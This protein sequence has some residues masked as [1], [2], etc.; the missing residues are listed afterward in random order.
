MSAL[1]ALAAERETFLS[2]RRSGIGGTD[3]AAI[4]GVSPWKTPLQVWAEKTGKISEPDLSE[5]ERIEWGNRLE[6]VICEA[7]AERTGRVVRREP[8]LSVMRG[9]PWIIA[10]VDAR[11][12]DPSKPGPGI[13]EAK[14]VGAHAEHDWDGEPPLHYVVQL[15]HYMMVEDYLWGGFAALIGGQQMVTTDQERNQSFGA[16]LLETELSFWRRHIVA[17]IPPSPLPIDRETLARLF[18][19]HDLDEIALPP[20]AAEWDTS[21][22]GIKEQLK[23][24]ETERDLLENRIKAAIGEHQAGLLPG[25]GKYTWKLQERAAYTV[26]A[27]S[28]RVLRRG[29]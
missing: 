10:H 24:L 12:T 5:L 17:D 27:S 29:K 11:M 1:A 14:A 21:L 7:Y 23:A 22:R 16:I 4:L 8:S 2:E 3:A 6:P 25:G 28:F 20:E 13:L 9:Y 26:A 19:R 18:P 15:Q